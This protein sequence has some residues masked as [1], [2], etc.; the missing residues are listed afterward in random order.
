MLLLALVFWFRLRSLV[1][2]PGSFECARRRGEGWASGIAVYDADEIRW[3][4]TISLSPRPAATWTRLLLAMSE[5][6]HRD[7]EEGVGRG[8]V[9]VTFHAS[10]GPLVL[11]MSRSAYAGLTSW[12]EAAPPRERTV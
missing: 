8:V 12:L 1:F 7:P 2:R 11:T 6:A 3:F 5:R 4:R 10:D 9:E